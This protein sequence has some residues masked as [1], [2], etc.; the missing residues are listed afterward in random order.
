MDSQTN[1]TTGSLH[2]TAPITDT[3]TSVGRS[4]PNKLINFTR[5]LSVLVV[6]GLFGRQDVQAV[7]KDPRQTQGNQNS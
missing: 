3:I 5:R 1:P 4:Y 2:K 7:S 6:Q